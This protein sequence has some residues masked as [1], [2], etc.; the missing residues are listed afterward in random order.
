MMIDHTVTSNDID[1]PQDEVDFIK[2]LVKGKVHYTKNRQVMDRS[3]NV[4]HPGK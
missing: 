1:I 4:S 2:D 3:I